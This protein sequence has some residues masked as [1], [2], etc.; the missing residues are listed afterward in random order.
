MVAL[1]GSATIGSLQMELGAI[2]GTVKD[3]QG[4]PIEGVTIKLKDLTRGREVEVKTDKRG[5]FYR[6]GLPAVDYEFTVEKEGYNPIQDHLKL[7]AGLEKRYD[8]KLVR[9]VPEGA[10]EFARGVAAFNHGDNAAAAAAFEAAMKKAP[11][12][13]EVRVNLALAYLRL[14]RTADAVAQ[15]EQAR[16]LAPDK[17]SVLFQLGEAYVD[18]KDYDKAVA[19]IEEGLKKA[20]N[21][22]DPVA[23]DGMVTLGAVFFA[24]G[25][26]DNAIAQFDRVL[27]IKADAPAPR[28][29]LA[30][31][32]S[33]KGEVAKALEEFK[34]VVS[35]APGTP[36]ATE[37]EAFIKALAKPKA[38]GA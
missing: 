7:S 29:G 33:S 34:R 38:P 12:L 2:Q 20:P 24:R 19:T 21:S 3:E 13:P 23:L 1:L 4:Q 30:K 25:D 17:P 27:A 16:A 31:A 8:F 36:E 18:M 9:A 37:A 11:D 10:E 15:L 32:L 26:N 22:S 14:S 35:S 5:T 28:L 6:R